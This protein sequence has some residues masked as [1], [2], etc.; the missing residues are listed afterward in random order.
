MDCDIL[1]VGLGDYRTGVRSGMM[2][3][4]MLVIQNDHDIPQGH[5][6][7]GIPP[8]PS[9]VACDHTHVGSVHIVPHTCRFLDD[10][11]EE[12]YIL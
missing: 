9:L 8:S 2:S 6:C 1:P 11:G 4:S 3:G 7:P 12:S 5:I 10:Y